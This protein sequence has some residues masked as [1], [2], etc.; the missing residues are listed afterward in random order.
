MNKI[1]TGKISYLN[2]APRKVRLVA[3]AL[4]G[5][6]ANEAEAQLMHLP[7]RS[8]TSLLKLLRSTIASAKNN[9]DINIENLKLKEI[10]VDG[11]PSP[12][13]FLPRA[14][15]RATT[16]L[17]RTSHVTMVLEEV[18][19]AKGRFTIPVKEK[20]KKKT[21]KTTKTAKTA[22]ADKSEKDQK[23][24]DEGVKSQKS[25][26]VLNKMFRRKSI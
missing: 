24:A 15:G 19:D 18:A 3:G 10:I 25:S 4:K 6:S 2:V 23:R 26:G 1:Q 7:N 16:I 17:K 21:P 14:Q 12:K 11:G 22:K 20:K 5:L 8:A 9:T 13:R